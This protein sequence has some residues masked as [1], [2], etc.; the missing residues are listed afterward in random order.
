MVA[1]LAG[2]PGL[3]RI[4]YTTYH[5]R[6]MADDLIEAHGEIDALMP[7]LHLPVQ[8]GS[9]RV[10]SA[11]NRRHGADDYRRTVDRLRAARGDI[12][13][14][15]DFI[16]GFPGETDQDFAATLKLVNDVTFAQAYSFKYSPRPGTP[17]AGLPQLAETVK[18]ERLATL[19]QLLDAQQAAFNQ[20]SVGRR[21]VVLLERQ[22]RLPGQLAGRSP[23]MQAVH[24]EAPPRLLGR[25]VE[26]GIDKAH[27]NSLSGR[28][29]PAS[30]RPQV[31]PGG[32]EARGHHVVGRQAW[33]RAEGLV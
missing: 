21:L 19:Q 3:A 8:S 16:V 5:P 29:A 10:L 30:D 28:I 11:M 12:A 2:L 22:G 13:L 1:S 17:A 23:Y 32:H 31:T 24:V 25:L 6:D 33:T 4:R 9:D 14:S 15:S 7:F 26:V 20:A 27:P 18:S